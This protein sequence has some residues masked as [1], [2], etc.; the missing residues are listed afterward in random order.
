M[1]IDQRADDGRSLLFDSEPLDA[2]LDL[3]GTPR[4]TLRL[5][6]DRPTAI[7]AA[8]LTEVGPE[9]ASTLIAYGIFN[10][11][12]RQG[13]DKSVP[14]TPGEPMTVSF[15]LNDLGQRIA[16]GACLRLALSTSYWPILWPTPETATIT[17]FPE[18]CR[19]DLPVYS[20]PGA[21]ESAAFAAPEVAPNVAF[22]QLRAPRR[23]RSLEPRAVFFTHSVHYLS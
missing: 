13:F 21:G 7:L 22:T 20:A 1:P 17:L 6:A 10:L 19:I 11:T 16:K 8:R 18:D 3:L 9:G 2:P 23:E 14:I 15:P 5:S 4:L 12:R